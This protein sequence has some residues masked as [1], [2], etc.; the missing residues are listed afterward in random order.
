MRLW[1]L[2]A[3]A[4]RRDLLFLVA[5]VPQFVPPGGGSADVALLLG[6]LTAVSLLLWAG[7]IAGLARIGERLARHHRWVE[8][9]TAASLV[10]VG[11]LL[12]GGVL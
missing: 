3:A 9:I 1:L 4:D 12:L 8:R 11:G 10:M 7:W 6:I 5:L 2:F